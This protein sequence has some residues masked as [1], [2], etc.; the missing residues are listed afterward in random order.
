M[1]PNILLTGHSPHLSI[2]IEIFSVHKF[3]NSESS[4]FF[5][6][7]SLTSSQDKVRGSISATERKIRV[8]LM[9]KDVK[10]S[11]KL[12]LLLFGANVQLR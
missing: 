7:R 3:I 5:F 8:T 10:I 1:K 9:E 6:T 2:C 11:L 4:I 12:E